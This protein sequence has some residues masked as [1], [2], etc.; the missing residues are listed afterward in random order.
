[1]YGLLGRDISLF[2]TRRSHVALLS[3]TLL[4]VGFQTWGETPDH[5][6]DYVWG[7]TARAMAFATL[8]WVARGGSHLNFYMWLGG[9]NRGRAA[10]AAITNAYATEAPLCPSGQRRYPKYLHFQALL[11]ALQRVAPIL[12]QSPSALHQEVLLPVWTDKGTWEL[13]TDVRMFSYPA[14]T[15][16]LHQKDIVDFVENA[17][18]ISHLV[19][20]PNGITRELQELEMSPYSAILR[21]K[22][23]AL[24]D[25]SDIP[26]KS[27]S[28]VRRRYYGSIEIAHWA[29]WWEPVGVSPLPSTHR[30]IS[31][32]LPIE[33]TLLNVESKVWSDYAWY[34]TDFVFPSPVTSQKEDAFTLTIVAPDANAYVVFLD[35]RFIGAVES[36]ERSE[37]NVPLSLTIP[38]VEYDVHRHALS[39]LSESLGSSNIIGRWGY[40]NTQA[41]PK[42]LVGDVVIS[43]PYGNV[44]LTDGTHVWRMFP[45]LYGTHPSRNSTQEE[46]EDRHPWIDYL[47]RE[48]LDQ[49]LPR[50]DRPPE[51]L[52]ILQGSYSSFLFQIEEYDPKVKG[53]FID[54]NSGRGH[55]W[56]NGHDLG[57][58]WN[59]TRGDGD[60]I[61]DLK[62]SQ[63]YYFLPFDYL[64]WSAR[65]EQWNELIFFDAFG[66]SHNR[67][68]LLL[69][70]IETCNDGDYE[71]CTTMEDEVDFA[72][73]CV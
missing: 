53:L 15:S 18:N 58:Y 40:H 60:S 51:K 68:R 31:D 39:I 57:R 21:L 34:E 27:K 11:L 9:Y 1:M 42:G 23:H 8:R 28:F 30:I 6:T 47:T 10:A 17:S 44:S 48:I 24:F 62:L 69:S 5:P 4:L 38:T 20:V 41:K 52:G 26:S 73:A 36:H 54:I 19:R 12:L 63:R 2:R 25:S 65:S 71:T 67:S 32:A 64:R 55:V 50:T 43:T 22:G 59:I 45:G 70:W 56:L 14:L 16:S 49:N 3:Q 61:A 72:D 37:Q 29:Y 7:K 46:K 33:Q 35:D 13:N 66:G